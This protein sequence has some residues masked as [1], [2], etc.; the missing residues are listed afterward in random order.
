MTNSKLILKS[1][2]P[3]LGVDSRYKRKQDKLS[4]GKALLE[5]RLQRLNNLSKSQVVEAK[6]LQIKYKMESYLKQPVYEKTNVFTDFLK[7]YIDSIYD[8][9]IMFAKDINVTPVSLSQ[10][11]NNH[12]EP[13]EEFMFRLMLHS[14]LTFK[15]ICNFEKKTWYQVYYHEKLCDT[16]GNQDTWK[17]E[18]RKHVKI[19][20]AV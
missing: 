9:R 12:R 1:D 2:S 18:E 10:V 4:E 19:E 5:A 16:M 7:S 15:G 6:L 14:E 8:K 17:P 13:K 11:L 20:N 3:E